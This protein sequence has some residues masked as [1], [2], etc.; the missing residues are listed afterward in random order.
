MSGAEPVRDDRNRPQ[1][2]AYT[3]EGR[4]CLRVSW[5]RYCGTWYCKQHIPEPCV[6]RDP[7]GDADL[8]D[9]EVR[10]FG[11]A[12]QCPQREKAE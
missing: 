11:T 9:P 5:G 6:G 7:E 10:A 4:Q 2:E 12:E 1:C 8:E 3:R